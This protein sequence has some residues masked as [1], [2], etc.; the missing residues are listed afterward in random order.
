MAVARDAWRVTKNV[1][2]FFPRDECDFAIVAT[3]TLAADLN[4][5]DL[6]RRV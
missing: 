6:S 5:N 4:D 3:Y 1:R 2:D